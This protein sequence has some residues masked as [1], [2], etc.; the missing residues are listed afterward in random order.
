MIYLVT[1]EQLAE[2]EDAYVKDDCANCVFADKCRPLNSFNCFEGYFRFVA[3]IEQEDFSNI[4]TEELAKLGG[5][6]NAV[7]ASRR[8]A[9]R[10]A[11]IAD[12]RNR[13]RSIVEEANEL[14]IEL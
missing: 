5:K 6:I 11:K 3:D 4:E 10:D 1:D 14:G 12:L 13:Y 2:V 9:E 7:V 8:K